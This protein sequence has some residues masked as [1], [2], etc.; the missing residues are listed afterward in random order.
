M[1]DI[2]LLTD[3]YWLPPNCEAPLQTT[4]G[5]TSQSLQADTLPDLAICQGLLHSQQATGLHSWPSTLC[6][7]DGDNAICNPHTL[8]ICLLVMWVRCKLEGK[9][10][11]AHHGQG[12]EETIAH[13]QSM[14]QHF[15]K[16]EYSSR[17]VTIVT[18]TPGPSTTSE[19]LTVLSCPLSLS[20]LLPALYYNT[21]SPIGSHLVK[22][23][24]AV[25]FL[26]G[27]DW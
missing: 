6:R 15:G 26:I 24:H 17:V 4:S 9:Q 1:A 14:V 25:C 19:F 22:S 8:Q 10:Q 11:I 3:D 16:D 27:I 18:V 5:T 2:Y 20:M 21:I 7:C 23:F 13:Y 12:F